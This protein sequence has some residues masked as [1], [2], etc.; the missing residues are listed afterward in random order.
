MKT[1]ILSSTLNLGCIFASIGC[2]GMDDPMMMST[3]DQASGG[4][5]D[6]AT[7]PDAADPNA[8]GLVRYSYTCGTKP[9]KTVELPHVRFGANYKCNLTSNSF[10]ITVTDDRVPTKFYLYIPNYHGPGTY[11]MIANFYIF[12]GIPVCVWPNLAVYDENCPLMRYQGYFSPCC[13]TMEDRARALTCTVV[14]QQHAL[15]RVTGTFACRIQGESE[16]VGT[17]EYCPPST[18]AEVHGSF[19]YGPNDCTGM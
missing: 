11:N 2:H 1:T 17:T 9:E 4:T 14:V 5:H 19:D 15:S 12:S 8:P 16:R 10:D 7:T 13:S 3:S 6:M 18:T